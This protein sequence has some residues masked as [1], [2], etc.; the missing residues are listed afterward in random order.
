MKYLLI[1]LIMTY[2]QRSAFSSDE[3]MDS[4]YDN[5]IGNENIYNNENLF[6][7]IL[8]SG[9]KA[10]SNENN[11]DGS[12]NKLDVIDD[13]TLSSGYKPDGS[14]DDTL[15]SGD[16]ADGSGDNADGSGDNTDGSGDNNTK[17]SSKTRN[18]YVIIVIASIIGII[19][20]G[21]LV[22]KAYK[23]FDFTINTMPQ[24]SRPPSFNGTNNNKSYINTVVERNRNSDRMYTF[25]GNTNVSQCTEV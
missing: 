12:G 14:D 2:Q 11:P 22:Y 13:D 3:E 18:Y 10:I 15:I 4:Y 9:L 5:F 1:L 6:T 19:I 21:G 8:E 25:S 20:I 17:N 16:N 7:N 24:R 23:A